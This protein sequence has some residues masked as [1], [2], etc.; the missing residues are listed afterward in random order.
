[1]DREELIQLL[2]AA[3]E[4]KEG[5]AAIGVAATG[6]AA[7]RAAKRDLE[8]ARLADVL[9]VDVVEDRLTECL[10]SSFDASGGFEAIRAKTVGDVREM[11]LHAPDPRIVRS[12]GDAMT[13]EM[14]AAVAKVMTNDQ[15]MRVAAAAYNPLAG[16]G[17]VG[18]SGCV[19]SGAQTGATVEPPVRSHGNR[20]RHGP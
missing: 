19:A 6:D 2:G 20:G 5:D 10:R 14:V 12:L 17:S 18:A 15:L 7:R 16:P 9:S 3:N 13:S 8:R 11:L 1:M 4:F